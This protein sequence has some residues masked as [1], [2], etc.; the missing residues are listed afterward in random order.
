[1]GKILLRIPPKNMISKNPLPETDMVEL[2][3]VTITLTPE[4]AETIKAAS[5][6]ATMLRTA[7]SCGMLY[8]TGRSDAKSGRRSPRYS[9]RISI[10]P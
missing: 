2:E 1:M 8:A 7:K 9:M 3:R 4:L 5:M 6:R 10:R